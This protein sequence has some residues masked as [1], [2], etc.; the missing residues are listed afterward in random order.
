MD[1]VSVSYLLG[2]VSFVSGFAASGREGKGILLTRSIQGD[3]YVD[4][5]GRSATLKSPYGYRVSPRI[6]PLIHP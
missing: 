2:V 3:V 5:W 1:K 6:I 4:F